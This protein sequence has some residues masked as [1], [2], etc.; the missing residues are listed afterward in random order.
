MKAIKNILDKITAVSSIVVFIAMVLMVTYQ[1]IARYFFASPSSVTEALTR[2]SFVW[3][4]I[5]SATYMFGQ[6]EHICISVVRDKLPAKVKEIVNIL[7]EIVTII[8]AGLVMIFG[9]FTISK[10]NLLQIDSILNIPTGII[11]SIIPICG[12]IIVFYSIYNI[13]LELKKEA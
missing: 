1:V 5:I 8:F 7:I 10:M 11:Y 9:G 12:V 4:I 13:M 2:Y 6:R 3:L